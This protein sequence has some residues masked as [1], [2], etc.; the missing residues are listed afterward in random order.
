MTTKAVAADVDPLSLERQVCFRAGDHQPVL[1]LRG[2]AR[3]GSR[4]T[5][6][7]PTAIRPQLA[8]CV[9]C[10]LCFDADHLRL[11]RRWRVCR[12]HQPGEVHRRAGHLAGPPGLAQGPLPPIDLELRIMVQCNRFQQC[13]NGGA[14]EGLWGGFLSVWVGLTAIWVRGQTLA[15][16]EKGAQHISGGPA[17]SVRGGFVILGV[18]GECCPPRIIRYVSNFK[19]DR[20]ATGQQSRA[21][22]WGLTPRA[23][24]RTPDLN[25]C[26]GSTYQGTGEG[27]L[28]VHGQ[29]SPVSS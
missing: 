5:P 9:P 3:R 8:R 7:S 24:Q 17:T 28:I 12:R 18:S 13:F 25:R 15:G 4:D 11:R 2:I 27:S 6:R 16:I 10:R 1:C 20:L 22:Y 29:A 19:R 14:R 23:Q 26:A 21:W